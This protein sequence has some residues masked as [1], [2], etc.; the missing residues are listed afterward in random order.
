MSRE[1]K[2]YQFPLDTSIVI[3]YGYNNRTG[4]RRKHEAVGKFKLTLSSEG[5]LAFPCTTGC[6]KKDLESELGV[7]ESPADESYDIDAKLKDFLSPKKEKALD[8]IDAFWDFP[9]V[10]KDEEYTKEKEKIYRPIE[11]EPFNP[12]MQWSSDP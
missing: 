7:D 5:K 1:E 11:D 3:G 12:N 2:D 6:P 4:K 9:N 8:I 10:E